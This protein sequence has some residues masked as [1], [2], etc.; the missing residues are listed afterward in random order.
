MEGAERISNIVLDLRR[1]S[2]VQKEKPECFDLG[3]V[4][5]TAVHWV[6]KAAREKLEIVCDLRLICRSSDV[7]DRFTRY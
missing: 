1:Y 5:K 3:Q 7:R 6:V 4:I 2:G